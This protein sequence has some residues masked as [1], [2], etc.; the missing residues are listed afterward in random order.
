MPKF[1]YYNFIPQDIFTI[2]LILAIR[3][4][5]AQNIITM[6]A[7]VIFEKYWNEPKEVLLSQLLQIYHHTF[8]LIIQ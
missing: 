8:I 4:V 3:L 1:H 6:D 7:K 2:S 5:R